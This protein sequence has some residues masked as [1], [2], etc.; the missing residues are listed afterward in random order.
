MRDQ[1][2]LEHLTAQNKIT[3]REKM[4]HMETL[5]AADVDT[6]ALAALIATAEAS[7][8]ELTFSPLNPDLLTLTA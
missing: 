5:A 3:S 2:D 6:I 7:G 4:R 1:V 8:V